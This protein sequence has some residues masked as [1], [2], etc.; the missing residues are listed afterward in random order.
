[1]AGMSRDRADPLS[2]PTWIFQVC[3]GFGQ[4]AR[5]CFLRQLRLGSETQRARVE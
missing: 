2:L 3:I 1:M 5:G 4:I